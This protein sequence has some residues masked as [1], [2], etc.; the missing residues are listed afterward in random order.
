[1]EIPELNN[2]AEWFYDYDELFDLDFAEL[3]DEF[4]S[5]EDIGKF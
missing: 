4:E 5:T 2:D 3:D 1:M